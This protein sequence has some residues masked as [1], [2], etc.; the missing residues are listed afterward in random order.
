MPTPSGAVGD[1]LGPGD[2]V[3]LGLTR[4]IDGLR[5]DMREDLRDVRDYI[6]RSESRV[7]ARVEALEVKQGDTHQL[8][9]EYTQAHASFH[10]NED[11]ERRREWSVFHDFIRT[12]E[13]DRARKDGALGVFRYGVELL[14]AHGANIAKVV[15]A[16]AGLGLVAS[17]GLHIVINP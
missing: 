6:T 4:L 8:L 16:L 2:V 11:S 7:T 10:E 15:L 12:A 3:G 9:T 1:D 5:D 14:S 17:G 13:L